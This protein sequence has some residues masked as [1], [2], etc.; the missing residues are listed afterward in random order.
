MT[1][2]RLPVLILA[3]ILET[4]GAV[5]AALPPGSVVEGALGKEGKDGMVA[6]TLTKITVPLR[7]EAESITIIGR[8]GKAE[9]GLVAVFKWDNGAT[10]VISARSYDAQVKKDLPSAA[11]LQPELAGT[12]LSNACLQLPGCRL[13]IRPNI[14]FYD[15]TRR[16]EILKNWETLPAASAHQVALE[17]RR[18]PR[19][20]QTWVDGRFIGQTSETGRLS[21]LELTV[22]AGGAVKDIAGTRENDARYVPLSVERFAN[23]GVMADAAVTVAQEKNSVNGMYLRL[24]Q[25]IPFKVASGA[26]NIALEKLGCM[27]TPSIDLNELYWERCTLDGLPE[28]CL[29][30]VPQDTYAFAH[31]LCAAEEDPSKVPAFTVRLTRYGY[32]RGDAMADTVVRLPAQG[33]PPG[34][35]V[36]Q[37]GKVT[38]GPVNGRKTVSLWLVR[39]PLKSGKIQDILRDDKN[40][41][42][43][44]MP[45]DCDYLD[46]E[47][48][49]PLAGVDKDDAF[50]PTMEATGRGY[51]PGPSSA[52]HVFGMTLE[53][54]PAALTVRANMP[55]N[56]FYASDHPEFQAVV[57]G[58]VAGTY[59]LAWEF[60]DP[61]G[62]IAMSGKKTVKLAGNRGAETVT[63]PV[64][65]GNGWYAT[66]FVLAD[67][68]GRVLV[69]YR[70]SFV[71]LPP[72]TRKAGVKSPHGTD[73]FLWT[74]IG[75]P[76]ISRVGMMLQRTGLRHLSSTLFKP[77]TMP[78]TVMAPYKVT[79]WCIECNFGFYNKSVDEQLL[80]EYEQYIAETLKA[81]PNV[82]TMMIFHET[83]AGEAPFAPELWGEKPAPM[84]DKAD[85]FF[86]EKRLEPALALAKMVRE[87]FPGL[88][89]QLGNSWSGVELV[90]ELLRRGYPRKYYDSL[91]VEVLGQTIIPEKASP[92]GLQAAWFLRQTA[93]KLGHN[94]APITACEEWINR[95][96][97]SLGL[98][99]QAEWY[100]RDALHARAYGFRSIP[101]GSVHDVGNGYFYSRWGAGGFCWRWPY[102]YPK[103]SCAAMATL[104]RV[105][106]DA[107]YERPAPTGSLSLYALEFKR[108]AVAKE[109]SNEWIYATWV[110]RGRCEAQFKFADNAEILVTDIYGREQ[111]FQNGDAKLTVSPAVQ[112]LTAKTR[113]ASV[114]TGKR[115]FPEDA[116]PITSFVADRMDKKEQWLVQTNK[117]TRLEQT[118]GGGMPHRTQGMFE[119]REVNDPEKG[120]CL[121]VELKPKGETWEMMHEY[122]VLK[123]KNP[124]AA[125]GPCEYAG[126][127]VKGNSGWGEIIW[128]VEDAEGEVWF[129]KGDYMDWQGM[130]SINFDGWNFLRIK[131]KPDWG[132]NWNKTGTG[133][134]KFDPPVKVT[135]IAVTIPRKMLYVTEMV[136]V[137][138][139]TVRLKDVCIF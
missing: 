120:K 75:G 24:G 57:T 27:N 114:Q 121:E 105:L 92:D 58:R 68:K 99:P 34:P 49:G 3:L 17:L 25:G 123:L 98:G 137:T 96:N 54:S 46:V 108:E 116:P 66:R 35:D 86:R 76:D 19:G 83:T 26:G 37:V 138:N 94:D 139:L 47:L 88:N 33:I 61:E 71:M 79:A 127:W 134:G 53:T 107:V 85:A 50:P 117:D 104:T 73:C 62:K 42:R 129:S 60:A 77:K 4:S 93:R 72:D 36:K 111:T 118:S 43:L 80:A 14:S 69:D 28:Q 70:G 84:T 40:R 44:D 130:V 41:R 87:K 5:L 7:P 59:A 38:Y 110:P 135:G 125:T 29:I 18:G 52:V 81:W 132:E 6:E 30:S 89:I 90:G 95:L 119:V 2:Q 100:M 91:A 39:V 21:K 64:N 1:I 128:E 55:I 74:H 97:G 45:A 115:S 13:F 22:A 131:L 133:N 82:D 101:L 10:T 15:E 9:P 32:S 122:V 16:K 8:T 136:P 23:P 51:R 103:P 20:A 112:Y 31:V 113:L 65:V 67:D 78:E 124:V 48:F 109:G 56:M 102:M 63:V 12:V 11:Y 126:I 106:D